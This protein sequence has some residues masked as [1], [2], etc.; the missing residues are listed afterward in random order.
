M[1]YILI[2]LLLLLLL[3]GVLWYCYDQVFRVKR[4]LTLEPK[5]IPFGS[6]YKNHR[7]I[8]LSMVEHAVS[9]P[10]R[11]VSATARDGAVLHARYYEAAPDAPVQILFHG[12]RSNALR[13]F[14]GGMPY[15]LESGW[16]VLLVDQRAHG[17]SGG[18]CL[19]FGILERWDVLS[20]ID[21]VNHEFGEDTPIVLGG[22]SMG[23]ATVLMASDLDLPANVKGIYADCGYSS[24]RAIIRKVMAERG[25]PV[26]L[27]YPLVRLAGRLIGGFDVDSASAVESLKH[28][29]LPVLFIHGEADAFV[30]CEMSRENYAACAGEK[31]LL[32]VPGAAHGVCF[33]LD[34]PRYTET[35][36][37]F[38]QK[39]TAL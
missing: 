38:L 13:D 6:I 21:Y 16:N 18:R 11:E 17:K 34:R 23:A 39:V 32:T 19:S 1:L 35:V 8:I 3:G 27:V 10:C 14:C 22:I 26:P 28:C 15:A 36:S 7:D 24:P 20:W 31:T 5:S 12:Y 29:R 25:L 9:I 4:E 33:V 2:P 30:P 37:H